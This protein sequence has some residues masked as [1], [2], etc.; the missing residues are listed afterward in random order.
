V[1][2]WIDNAAERRPDHPALVAGGEVLSWAQLAEGARAASAALAAEAVGE[3]DR[4]A[5]AL[6]AGA[7]F[8]AA[9]H[10]TLRLRAV[11]VPV[12]LRLGEGEQKAITGDTKLVIDEPLQSQ[13]PTPDARRPT[14]DARRPTPDTPTLIIHTSG[15]TG[16]PRPVVLTRGNWDAHAWAS[17]A[18]LGHPSDE[19]WLCCLPLS[20]VGGLGTL[21]RAAVHATTVV[22]HERFDAAHVATALHEGITGVSLVPTMLK[23]VLD[24]GLQQP[25][26]LRVALIGGGPVPAEQLARATAASIPVAQT[27][28]LTEACS[29][30][31]AETP[32]EGT[33]TAGRA[34]PG[35]EVGVDA[36]GEILVRGPTVAPGAADDDG[37]L[38]TGDLG[39]LDP[40]GRLTVVGRRSE[41]IVTGGENVAPA[42][43]EAALEA[44]PAV[45][46]AAVFGRAD[47]EWG[48]RVVAA[49]VLR[50]DASAADLRAHAAARL[51]G[52]KVPKEIEP[53]PELPRT[54]SGKLRRAELR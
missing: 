6:P 11:A 34:L 9:L 30:V 51:A 13:G 33:A 12:D 15:T 4:V 39:V 40:D 5:L 23:R 37:F 20:H 47:P 48:E 14:P 17:A 44:H 32:G 24:H 49:V 41:T 45:A 18:A 28:G 22:L 7:P 1:Q 38:H 26:L 36:G 2:P 50:T 52:F 53:R 8:V 29:Q 19:R 16:T 3:G 35:T 54:A 42:E 10:G 25:A 27:Y 43:V 21:V 46:E 31:T